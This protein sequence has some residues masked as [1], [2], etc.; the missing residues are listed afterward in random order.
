MKN[1]LIAYFQLFMAMFLAGSSVVVGKLIVNVFPVFL[2]QGIT[3]LIALVGIFPLAW[4]FEGNVFKERISKRD[5]FFMWL[6]ALTGMFLFRIFLLYGLKFTTATESGII[7]ST[8]PAILA[9]LSLILLK[10][11]IRF[12]TWLGIIICI[13]GIVLVNFVKTSSSSTTLSLRLLGNALILLA[14]I[15]ESLFTVFRKKISFSDKP[16]TSTLIIIA[17]SLLMFLPISV[18]ESISFDYTKLV[19]YDFIPLIIYGLFC[20]VI[21]YICWFSGVSKVKISVAAGFTGIMPISSVVLS[22]LILHETITWQHIAGVILVLI[23][24]YTIAFFKTNEK[25]TLVE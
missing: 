8:N 18:Y 6:Q 21:A 25:G 9:I 12:K 1:K 14:V 4:I 20:T 2:S 15:G 16:I 24:I 17:F 13:A 5:L 10:E 11:K 23:G 3:L 19:L 22:F 7:T